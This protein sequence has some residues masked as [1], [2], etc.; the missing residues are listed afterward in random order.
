M[1]GPMAFGHYIISGASREILEARAAVGRA[2]LRGIM[3]AGRASMIG[4]TLA[5]RPALRENLEIVF[6]RASYFFDLR[7]GDYCISRLFW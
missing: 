6:P 2:V 4:R 1:C 7:I 5:T 3:E